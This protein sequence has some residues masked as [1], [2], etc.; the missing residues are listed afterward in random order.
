MWPF[1]RKQAPQRFVP[2]PPFIDGTA[3][4]SVGP[5]FASI[6]PRAAE[7]SAAVLGAV[8][9]IST[10]IAGLPAYVVKADDSRA[11]VPNHPLMRLIRDGCNSSEVVVR[12]RRTSAVVMPAARQRAGE[13]FDRRARRTER[14]VQRAMAAGHAMGRR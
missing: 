12:L 11:D 2:S 8:N 9:A 6:S 13:D 10:T 7:N 1:K 14:L 5:T 4:A 3:W